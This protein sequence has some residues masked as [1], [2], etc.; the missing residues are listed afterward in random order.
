MTSSDGFG[1]MTPRRASS[2]SHKGPRGVDYENEARARGFRWVAGVDEAGRGPLAGPVVA[3]A[4]LFEKD[5]FNAEVRDS[6]L[7]KAKKRSSL[8]DWIKEHAYSWAVGIADAK[9]IDRLNILAASLVAMSRAV[10]GLNQ[11]PDFL[12]IDGPHLIPSSHFVDGTKQWTAVPSQRAIKKGDRLCFSIAAASII[13][14]VTR[15]RIMEELDALYPQYGFAG[16][17]GYGSALHAEALRSYG[18]SPV[19]RRSFKP[20]SEMVRDQGLLA[21]IIDARKKHGQS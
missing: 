20:V 5:I 18:P 4:V 3:A 10:K 9:E 1:L 21:P 11:M 12:M 13:A 17:K 7:L 8:C 14:K 2:E 15:D 6:K 16:H 19:H